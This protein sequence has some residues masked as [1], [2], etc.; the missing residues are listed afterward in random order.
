MLV[1]ISTLEVG[2]LILQ[3]NDFLKKIR[4]FTF[5]AK[6]VFFF[7]KMHEDFF[8]KIFKIRPNTYRYPPPAWKVFPLE[9]KNIF[10]TPKF[11]PFSRHQLPTATDMQQ[12]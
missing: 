5:W 1:E 8:L 11:Q 10:Q 6:I 2:Y 9:I 12:A 7:L 4:V 3:K